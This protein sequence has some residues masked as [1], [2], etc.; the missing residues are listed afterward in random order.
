MPILRSVH[1]AS[2]QLNQLTL[3]QVTMNDFFR[4][5]VAV[6]ENTHQSEHVQGKN[7]GSWRTKTIKERSCSFVY[8]IWKF[9]IN[10][11]SNFNMT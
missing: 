11:I 5:F 7:L 4:V 10:V 3:H 8:A 2:T 6:N 1:L 9:V